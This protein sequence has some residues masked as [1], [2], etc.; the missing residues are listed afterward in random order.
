MAK[1]KAKTIMLTQ[2]LGMVDGNSRGPSWDFLYQASTVKHPD[3]NLGDRV[4]LPD[5]RVFRYG[6]AG[7]NL[8]QMKRG[9]KNN[10][11]LVTEL[12][13]IGVA[14]EIGDSVIEVTFSDTDGVAN[15]GVIAEDELRGGYISLYRGDHRQQRGIIGNTARANGDTGN[16]KI[17]L[18]A[19]LVT[20]INEDDNLEVIGNPYADLRHANDSQI[21]AVM[22]MPCVLAT[23]GQYFWIQTWGICRVTP[24][25]AEL[26]D[27]TSDRQF[28]FDNAGSVY[29][30]KLAI[31][32]DDNSYQHA[33]FIVE[34]VDGAAGSAAPFIN[35]QINP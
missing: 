7:A 35:L 22:G 24:S 9:V 32:A 25:Q 5:G 28:V 23:S 31:A 3:F 34:R 30:H 10:S 14:A 21:G 11:L 27:V 19:A 8:E 4:C 1:G 15:D 18:D 13:A 29:S 6:K 33:G 16:T 26:G 2:T 20:A 17:W 12:D